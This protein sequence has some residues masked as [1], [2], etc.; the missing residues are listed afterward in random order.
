MRIIAQR[1]EF[2]KIVKS[3]PPEMSFGTTSVIIAKIS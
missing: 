2:G 1:D 3:I